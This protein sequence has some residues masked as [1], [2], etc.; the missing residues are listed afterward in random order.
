MK[1][2][3]AL[4]LFFG[5]VACLLGIGSLLS[6]RLVM[7]LGLE[8]LVRVGALS[9]LGASAFLAVRSA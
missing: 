9:M 6:A 4:G 1:Q 3:I 2:W 8:R 7:Q 5:L